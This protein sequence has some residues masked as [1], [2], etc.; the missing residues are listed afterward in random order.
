MHLIKELKSVHNE[1]CKTLVNEIEENSQINVHS[2]SMNK[3]SQN[4]LNM[5]TIQSNLEIQGN[6]Y[7]IRMTYMVWWCIAVIS[8]LGKISQEGHQFLWTT[9]CA[10]C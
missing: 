6:S 7:Q 10:Q 4:H 5:Y 3:K 9:F 1:N 8:A 2:V